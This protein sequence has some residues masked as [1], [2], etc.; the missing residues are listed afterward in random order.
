MRK[1][2]LTVRT[3]PHR[4]EIVNME[5]RKVYVKSWLMN[6]AEI[7][8][9]FFLAALAVSFLTAAITKDPAGAQ[10]ALLLSLLSFWVLFVNYKVEPLWLFCIAHLPLPA[11]VLL[12]PEA[13][14]VRLV[15]IAYIAGLIGYSFHRRYSAPKDTGDRVSLLVI[16][17]LLMTVM[18]LVCGAAG[19]EEYRPVL[20]TSG[21]FFCIL[22]MIYVHTVVVDKALFAQS[23]QSIRQPLNQI[24]RANGRMLIYFLI[25]LIVL[26]EVVMLIPWDGF[27][28]GGVILSLLA[29][30]VLFFAFLL[31]LIF[32][33]SGSGEESFVEEAESEAE[34][35]GASTRG[36]WVVLEKIFEVLML[37]L[38]IAG[39]S[40]LIYRAWKNFGGRK[41]FRRQK[42]EEEEV[43][44]TRERI[45]TVKAPRAVRRRASLRLS[46]EQRVRRLFYKKVDRHMD[47]KVRRSDTPEQIRGK[48]PG[49]GME[50][51]VPLYD[52]ARYSSQPVTDEELRG[53]K[54][55]EK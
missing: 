10:P 11:V 25:V 15:W 54:D 5:E 16:G 26:I 36:V 29:R 34:N 44:E 24:R 21:V 9:N 6:A 18:Y 52:R 38:M 39:L 4:T 40:Y 28:G 14:L 23:Q 55:Q 19:I 37:I 43:E 27:T 32:S 35:L 22:Y 49:E 1:H 2:G 8:L 47:K 45:T 46:N 31:S 7:F 48:L 51:L 30:V 3:G 41:R 33:G 20:L 42:A 17:M 12:A 13:E 50:E 53:L